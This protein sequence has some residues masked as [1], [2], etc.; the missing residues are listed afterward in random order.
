LSRSGYRSISRWDA[1][2]AKPS[3][4][5]FQKLPRL[6]FWVFFVLCSP[7][8][9]ACLRHSPYG[10]AARYVES[11]QQFNY[12]KCYSLLSTPDRAERPLHQFLTEIPLAPNVSPIWFRP[13]LHV[14]RFELGDEHLNNDGITAYVSLHITSPDLP[15]WERTIDAKAESDSSPSQLADRSLATGTYPTVRYDDTIFLVKEKQ[16]W[17]VMVGFASRDRLLDLY[18]QAM[19]DFYR[20][21]LS[22]A[23]A[24][25]HSIV[26]E[27]EHLPGTGNLGLAAHIRSELAEMSKV[28]AETATAAA[29]GSKLKMENVVMRMAEER[30]PA[31]FGAVTNIGNRPID[32][33]S[34][35]VTWYEGRGKN[36]KVVQREEHSIVITPIEFTDFSR[37]VIPFLPGEKRQFGFILDAPPEV[38]QSAAPY[39]SIGSV[40]FTELPA[41][42][43][44]LQTSASS[45][46]TH[47]GDASVIRSV[48]GEGAVA[49]SDSEGATLPSSV[50]SIIAPHPTSSRRR[51]SQQ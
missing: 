13:I 30:V 46:V 7:A 19:L 29:Y 27:L 50:P 17:R 20:G 15:L 24:Q 5:K 47:P 49:R 2:R 10:I 35:A 32:E 23:I 8:L 36:L 26:N 45:R 42:L 51:D 4:P 12:A 38:Q 44:L 18:R 25:F 43:A 48:K 22:Q 31:I 14:M 41:R 6:L 34:L 33:L 28:K 1:R 3:G 16:H 40:A 9:S 37:L 39:V 21:R 11:L